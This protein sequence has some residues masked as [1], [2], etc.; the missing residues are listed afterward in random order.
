MAL[1]QNAG[2]KR[3]VGIA[4]NLLMS[5]ENP[6]RRVSEIL[7]PMMEQKIETKAQVMSAPA[8]QVQAPSAQP[9]SAVKAGE[10]RFVKE[11]SGR[12]RKLSFLATPEIEARFKKARLKAGFNTIEDAYNEAIKRF[13]DQVDR[14]EINNF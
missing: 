1:D 4:R 8:P 2:K 3:A 5:D 6:E 7:A 9:T 12:T 11:Q 13:C 14:G 10:T